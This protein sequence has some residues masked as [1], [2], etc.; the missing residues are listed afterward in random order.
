[1]VTDQELVER[2]KRGENE[3][4]GELWRRHEPRVMALCR[5]FLRGA[6]T[7]PAVDAHDLAT[8]TFIRALHQLDHYQD[9]T[10]EGAS[11]QAWLLEVARRHC[12]RFLEKQ[13]RR[14]RWSEGGS[15]EEVLAEQPD[16]APSPARIV[17]ERELLRLAALEINAL[18]ERY[19]A[20]CRL[21]LEEYSHQGIAAV[22]GISVESA[23]KRVQRARRMLQPRLARLLELEPGR[24]RLPLRTLERALTE[25]VSDYRIVTMTLPSGGELQ[26]YL[27]VD[28]QAALREGEIAAR[29]RELPRRPRA[30]KPRLELAELCYHCGQWA[31]ARELY[32][33]VLALQ[34][35]C[36]AASLRLGAMLG[37]E[38]QP[39]AAVGVYRQALEREPPPVI[40][41]QLRAHLRVAEGQD[42]AAAAAFREAIAL[43]PEVK[44]HYYGLQAALGRLSRYEEQLAT[45]A[46]LRERDPADRHGLVQ[47]YTPC[48]RLG[49]F[50]LA[51]P[52]L[53]RAVAL[54]PHD[55]LALR[56][57]FEVRMNLGRRDAE[58]LALAERL[59]RLA[60]QFVGSWTELAWIY[61]ELGRDDESLAVLQQFL[62]DHPQNAEAHAALAWRYHYLQRAPETV[63]HARR[64]YALDPHNSHIC[65]TLLTALIDGRDRVPGDEAFPLMAEIAA[66]F[67]HDSAMQMWLSGAYHARGRMPEALSHARH[68]AK[69]SPGAVE[70]Q[71]RLARLYTESE[72]WHAAA[73]LYERLL[74]EPGDWSLR[75][76]LGR[77][78]ALQ[79]LGDPR[80][81]AFLAEAG[82]R[83]QS[84]MDYL[85][86]GEGL[87]ACG[88]RDDAIAAYR[89]SLDGNTA[90]P[91][92]IRLRAEEGLQR[93]EAGRECKIG[94]EQ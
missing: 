4:F 34:P 85:Y 61:A 13:Q 47:V 20:P 79:A 86:L 11:F 41:A 66:R 70:V 7:D 82:T 53:E 89:R 22:L 75:H 52:L 10:A 54:D 68:A 14:S 25:I 6:H 37:H 76:L 71:S 46:A 27:W 18:P 87:A 48:A 23:A 17:E 24:E 19:R 42:E 38:G 72:Q 92:H 91:A 57:L 62:A 50:D 44:S 84:S 80:V 59:V 35:A 93:L 29:R 8:E 77:A 12:L 56:Q 43:A 65:W 49:R 88:R 26:L 78:R 31:A 55:A 21:F 63:E 2:T 90:L 3:A 83:A 64:A 58:T 39:E 33:A 1:M 32:Q 30:W 36:A 69:L 45:L 9:Q 16:R 60:P 28:R 94:N 67:P 5:R 40:A 15:A 51:Q 73:E 81:D 74:Q